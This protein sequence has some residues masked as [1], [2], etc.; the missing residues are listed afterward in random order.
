MQKSAIPIPCYRKHL[1]ADEGRVRAFEGTSDPH[2]RSRDGGTPW[3]A[4]SFERESGRF[5]DESPRQAPR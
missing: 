3:M 4:A 5:I 2:E 1:T